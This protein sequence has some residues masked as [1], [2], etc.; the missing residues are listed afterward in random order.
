MITNRPLP[1]RR[2]FVGS[3]WPSTFDAHE[4]FSY[5]NITTG[6]NQPTTYHGLPI[7]HASDEQVWEPVFSDTGHPGIVYWLAVI[8]ENTTGSEKYFGIRLA[9]DGSVAYIEDRI[10]VANN[11]QHGVCLIGNLMFNTSGEPKGVSG[12]WCPYDVALQVHIYREDDAA[13]FPVMVA[14]KNYWTY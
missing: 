12:V 13:T 3:K 11:G 5:T 6:P 8:A 2:I 4:Y 1:P 7:Y 14:V 9:I 10:S